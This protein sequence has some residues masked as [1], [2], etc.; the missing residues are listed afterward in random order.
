MKYM[1][2]DIVEVINHRKKDLIGNRYRVISHGVQWNDGYN[3]KD[4]ELE[5][6]HDPIYP[7]FRFIVRQSDVRLCRRRF[8]DHV[9]AFFIN[10]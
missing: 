9:R 2:G 4:I 5:I 3:P 6:E 8:I 10:V 1:K 7:L